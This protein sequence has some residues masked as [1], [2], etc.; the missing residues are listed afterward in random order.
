MNVRIADYRQ[1]IDEALARAK[2]LDA[3]VAFASS[4]GLRFRKIESN[5]ARLLKDD[6]TVRILVDL[7]LGHTHPDFLDHVL[8][9]EAGGLPVECR[10]YE[11]DGGVFHP[12]LY[13]F[14]LDDD[15]VR[16]VTGSANWTGEAY[17]TNIEHGIVLE[18]DRTEPI[19][20]EAQR[21]F[22]NLWDSDNTRLID[23]EAADAYRSY[24]RRCQGVERKAR[25]EAT[26]EWT[27]LQARL[28]APAPATEPTYWLTSA[29]DLPESEETAEEAILRLVGKEG[30]W[31]IKRY[32]SLSRNDEICF[33][34]VGRQRFVAHAKV[35]S[36]VK[37]GPN[38][39]L[40]TPDKHR[41]WFK[42]KDAVLYLDHPVIYD[43]KELRRE[44]GTYAEENPGGFVQGTRKIDRRQFR[45]LTRNS[46]S[47]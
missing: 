44:L 8:R 2:S 3:G 28:T 35:D 16:V 25:R 34:V 39:R 47:V 13:I 4:A 11:T 33:Y 38:R 5:L 32:T 24:W 45:L 9:W 15:T 12:K 7:S 18:G 40:R 46:H 37:K 6:G 42:L 23:Q 27:R 21:F 30:L 17:S 20:A 29:R 43:D 36:T 19:I 10:H 41:W 1:E 14:H 31:G 22:D 26:K